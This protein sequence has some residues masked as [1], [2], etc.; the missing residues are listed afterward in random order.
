MK[1]NQLQTTGWIAAH[2]VILNHPHTFTDRNIGLWIIFAMQF[3]IGSC[4][5]VSPNTGNKIVLKENQ[6]RFSTADII[7]LW[8]EVWTGKKPLTRHVVNGLMD[9]WKELG[10]ISWTDCKNPTDGRIF[11]IDKM[12][13]N[14]EKSET[15]SEAKPAAPILD[16][17]KNKKYRVEDEELPYPSEA[18]RQAWVEWC[19]FRR[20]IK[21]PITKTTANKQLTEMAKWG[22]KA[23]IKSMGQSVQNSWQGLFPPQ[24]WTAKQARKQVSS[25]LSQMDI[26]CQAN[27]EAKRK[28]A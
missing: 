14:V 18:F 10:L 23:A 20:E 7:K 6:Q 4:E 26:D 16:N 22:E 12:K 9:K 21:K 15:E 24:G 13:P 25:G 11:T 17:N 5:V 3:E 19:G 28:A 2:R 27:D 1:V 8:S